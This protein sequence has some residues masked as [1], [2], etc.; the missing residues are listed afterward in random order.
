MEKTN[1]RLSIFMKWAFYW[2]FTL[3]LSVMIGPLSSLKSSFVLMSSDLLVFTVGGYISVITNKASTVLCE[4]AD[5]LILGH[6][7]VQWFFCTL[8]S[9]SR[10]SNWILIINKKNI[11][12]YTFTRHCDVPSVVSPFRSFLWL[13]NCNPLMLTLLCKQ[14]LKSKFIKTFR[15]LK[16]RLLSINCK[17]YSSQMLQ[18]SN[19]IRQSL[20]ILISTV[21]LIGCCLV[22]GS[23]HSF[24]VL[25]ISSC[26]SFRCPV[27][28]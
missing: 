5:L 14:N 3:L 24:R 13:I 28:N 10:S 6:I 2:C 12:F 9:K 18:R 1:K 23:Q 16:K 17:V 20:G 25:D 11:Y 19:I 15:G 4:E 7:L 27:M 26:C 22:T 8:F 21:V